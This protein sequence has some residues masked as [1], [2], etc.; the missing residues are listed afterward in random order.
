MAQKENGDYYYVEDGSVNDILSSFA[1]YENGGNLVIHDESNNEE[2]GYVAGAGF[3]V[4]SSRGYHVDGTQVV[5]GQES[6][7]VTSLTDNSGG[8]TDDT[9]AAVSGSGADSTINDNFAELA[10]EVNGII[11]TL[12]NHGLHA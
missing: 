8:S 11:T 5:G 1:F 9:V 7:N 10:D 6:G 2:P 4:P 3:D 12:K